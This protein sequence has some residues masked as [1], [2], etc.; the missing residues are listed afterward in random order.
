MRDFE[1]PGR[2][3]ATGKN[4]MA[5]TS[6]STATAIAVEILK[7]GGNA[8]D[9]AIAA[10]A[11]QGVVEAGSTGIG[12]DCFALIS[13]G[14]SENVL[15]YNG[16]GRAPAAAAVEWYESRGAK[17]IERNSPH[18]VTV[19]GAVDAWARLVK[20]HG[21]LSLAEIFAPAISLASG[22]YT[23]SPRIAHDIG[24]QTD[25]LKRDPTARRTFLCND[26]AP[27][28]GSIQRQPELAET[29]TAIGR[30]GPDAFYCGE[31]AT[32]MVSYLT[33]LG[34]LHTLEDFTAAKGEYVA[35]IRTE[36]RGR[37][38]YECPPNGQGVVALMI[39]NIL[40]RF[41]VRPDPLDVDNLHT[42]I[43]AT[44]LAY[45]ARDS[46]LAD[47]AASDVPIDYLL[48]DRLAD[49][50]AAKIDLS[51]AIE[52]LPTFQA[53]EHTDTVYIS[54]VDKDR[55]AVS[56]I[57]SIFSP[58][59]SGLVS[60]KT[61]VLFHNRGQSFSL[62]RGHPNQIAPRK[63][64][65][66]TIIPGM[67][68]E[69]G[70]ACMPFGVMGGHYQAMGHAH[71]LAK[72]FDHGLDLQ[73]AIDLPRLFPLP[74]TNVVEAETR[75]RERHGAALEARGFKLKPPSW[76]IGGAQAIWIDWERGSLIGGSDCR[77]DGCAIGF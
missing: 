11:V 35:P 19:P 57:N 61:G 49:E 69:N 30:E 46:F 7:S 33:S 47:P 41:K 54:V 22:G 62:T 26:Q 39:L 51:R 67:V 9:A 77:K 70:R 38:I 66:H 59:G 18:A 21:R 32:D 3:V 24:R 50:L 53:I 23:I 75:L 76:A 63:R 25:L 74:G 5:A 28:A 6:H 55:N 29:L 15:A 4:G 16:S 68:A 72:L 48:S 27:E 14:G 45:A 44:R 12:G 52:N 20:D 37:A 1:L 58:Y 64:P 43:E 42:E 36:F 2:S 60:P 71:L 17:A 34:G 73:S 65:M 31:I 13:L 40:S 56:L 10:C 8:I